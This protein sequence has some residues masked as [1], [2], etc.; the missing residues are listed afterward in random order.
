MS[1]LRSCGPNADRLQTLRQRF[2][3][4]PDREHEMAINRLR[5]A[6]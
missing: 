4:R 5:S 2:R 3:D 6:C 1:P